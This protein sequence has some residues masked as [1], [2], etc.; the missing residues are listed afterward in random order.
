MRGRGGRNSEYL[1]ALAL[2]IEGVEGVHCLAADTDGRD[3]S[4]HNAGVF[5]DGTSVAR[6]AAIGLNPKKILENHDAYTVF[7]GVDDLLMSGPTG[8]NVNDFRVFL[9]NQQ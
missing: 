2:G 3:G 8:T 5:C 1:L 7:L 9:I 6:M 4:E